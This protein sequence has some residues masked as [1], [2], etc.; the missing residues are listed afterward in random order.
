MKFSEIL[1]G[2]PSV[3]HVAAL[4]L[5]DEAGQRLA[6]IENRTGQA[7][8]LAVYAYLASKYG[9][10]NLA[11]ANEGLS[12]FAEHTEH[13]RLNPGSHPNIDRLLSLAKG[14]GSLRVNTLLRETH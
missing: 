11:A 9:V 6:V 12:L 4:E 13:A 8:S 2:L 1:R 10:I 3:D 7:G 5:W 14:G